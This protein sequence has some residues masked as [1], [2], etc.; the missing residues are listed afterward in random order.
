MA[1]L[2][3]PSGWQA[4]PEPKNGVAFT[5]EELQ[6][7]VGGVLKLAAKLDRGAVV[8]EDKDAIPKGLQLNPKAGSL[9]R[10]DLFGNVLVLTADEWKAACDQERKE[11]I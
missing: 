4:F 8:L 2:I 9:A 11:G 10:I 1:T 5:S 3:Y 6:Q 7:L